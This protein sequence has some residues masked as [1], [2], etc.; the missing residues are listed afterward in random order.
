MTQSR[1]KFVRFLLVVLITFLPLFV[2]KEYS[3]SSILGSD[4]TQ[5]KATA[6]ALQGN[7]PSVSLENPDHTLQAQTESSN[8]DSGHSDP[9]SFILIELAIIILVAI[10][11]RWAAIKCNQPAVL[12]E[13]LIGVILGNVAYWLGSPLSFFI[14]HLSDAGQIFERI[15][16]TGTTVV[17]AAKHVF[18]ASEL[19]PGGMG[20]RLVQIMTGPGANKFIIMGF[21]LWLFSNLGVILLLF[22]VGLESSVK[23]MLEVGPKATKV[24]IVGVVCPFILGLIASIW[25]L[26]DSES[27]VYLFLAATFCATSVGITARVFKDLNKIQTNEAKIILGAA[28]VDDI[29]ALV[30]LAIVVGIVTTGGVKLFE[31]GRILL[32]SIIFLGVIIKYGERFIRWLLPYVSV[33]DRNNSKLLFPLALAFLL[34]WLANLIELATIVGAFAAG[35]ILDDDQFAMHE[36]T[37]TTMEET[38]KPLETIFAPIFFVLMGM[39]VNLG[40]FLERETLWLSLAFILVAML[41]KIVAGIPAGKGSDRMTVGIGMLPRG[42][43]GLIFASIGKGLGVVTDSI[44][45]AV[46]IMVI[47]TTLITPFL[48]KWSLGRNAAI[49]Q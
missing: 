32:F 36:D 1:N 34:A 16:V 15:W 46:V 41:G 47:V 23:E 24:A 45:S 42:E 25:L 27:G 44:F 26:P 30:I 2:L 4:T 7:A 28:V 8:H 31:V 6:F 40:T 10:I 38:I 48:L 14:M 17:D 49:N 33:L 21:S 5:R 19:E 9:F 43:V 37:K 3:G 11:G 39:Q 35:L 29:L 18:P 22:M 13:L 20:H 12:G